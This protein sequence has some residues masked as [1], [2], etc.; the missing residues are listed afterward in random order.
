MVEGAV[1]ALSEYIS[2]IKDI[3]FSQIRKRIVRLMKGKKPS[4]IIGETDSSTEPIT[5]IVDSTGLTTTTKGAYIEDK[6]RKEKRRFVKL[7]ILADRQKDRQNQGISSH[8]RAHRRF[9][10]ICSSRK[11]DIEEGKDCK[12]V[13]RQRIRRKEEFQHPSW[14]NWKLNRQ[15]KS[16][17]MLELWQ[18]D[19]LLEGK[20][21][22]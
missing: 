14:M 22:S 7:H 11:G 9:K 19:L 1:E 2:F 17:R 8:V 12:G 16:E 18:E 3:C 21:L 20:K 13:W 6:W 5:A 10:E 15:S 4:E